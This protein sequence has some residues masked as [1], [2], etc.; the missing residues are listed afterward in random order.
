MGFF[1]V[2]SGKTPEELEQQ[3]DALLEK[4]AYGSAKVEFEKALDKWG[5]KPG[6]DSGFKP[7]LEEKIG[8]CREA[9]A[10]EHLQTA[11]NLME[12]GEYR[13]AGELLHLALELTGNLGLRADIEK[14]LADAERDAADVIDEAIYYGYDSRDEAN[15]E[16][17]EPDPAS[18]G[19]DYFVALC[20]ALPDA[21][22][23]AYLDYG[24]SFRRGFIAL[25]QGDFE[26]AA[27]LLAQAMEEHPAADS[28]IPLELATAYFNLGR[29][30]EA[31][32]LM[33]N[34]LT[35]HPESPRVY[36]VFCD[37]LW[38]RREFE[39]AR[40]LLDGCPEE[41]QNSGLIHLLR[42]ETYYQEGNYREA[43][44]FYLETLKSYGWDENI[45]RALARTYEALGMVTEARDI[46]GEIMVS[47]QGCGRRADPAIKRKFADTS[48]E[49]GERSTNLLEIYLSLSQEDSDDRRDYYQKISQI[50]ESA[51]NLKEARRFQVIAQK[52]A[53]RLGSDE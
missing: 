10:A 16:G 43:Q 38:E 28:Y 48:F 35:T 12:A 30:E 23:D 14:M 45:A 25:N 29:T 9:L 17:E 52:E 6:Q 31:R 41:L 24:D 22:Q 13:E 21:E 26:S 53:E 37:I 34:T 27:T 7:R 36:S 3:G 8:R 51:G 11:E 20:H 33:E 19:D 32:S 39:R 15:K 1:R 4:G 5:K 40:K 2:F 46:Y 18:S 50:Y 44:S 47:C 49:T 42:G